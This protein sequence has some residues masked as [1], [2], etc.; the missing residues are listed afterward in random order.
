MNLCIFEKFLHF[1]RNCGA[2]LDWWATDPKDVGSLCLCSLVFSGHG[3]SNVKLRILECFTL[4]LRK[5]TG[6]RWIYA[7]Q[8]MLAKSQGLIAISTRK[9]HCLPSSYHN[10]NFIE[11]IFPMLTFTKTDIRRGCYTQQRNS[12]SGPIEPFKGTV[13]QD[14]L[15]LVFFMN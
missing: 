4:Y 14:F 1:I 3:V 13:S 2:L 8:T 10:H 7:A 11:S 6:H 12:T 9:V 5:L 15:L